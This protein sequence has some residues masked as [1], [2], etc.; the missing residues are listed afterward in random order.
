LS[1]SDYNIAVQAHKEQLPVT[2]I[3]DL[4]ADGQR[5]KLSESRDI[6]IIRDENEEPKTSGIIV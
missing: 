5:W 6:R 3:G 1:R 2:V 4:E